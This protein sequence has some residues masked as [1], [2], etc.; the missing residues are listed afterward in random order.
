MESKK[1]VFSLISG[2]YGIL[3]GTL[4][5]GILKGL[6]V[7]EKRSGKDRERGWFNRTP[8]FDLLSWDIYHS[9]NLINNKAII[10]EIS[11]LFFLPSHNFPHFDILKY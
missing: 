1:E 5:Y 9:G 6:A 10:L 2:G 4:V 8:L 11:T 7:W 3:E